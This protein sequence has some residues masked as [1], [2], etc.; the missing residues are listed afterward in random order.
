MYNF[1][2]TAKKVYNRIIKMEIPLTEKFQGFRFAEHECGRYNALDRLSVCKIMYLF[3][4]DNTGLSDMVV[5]INTHLLFC[6]VCCL[7]FL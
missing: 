2:L 5:E 1:N 7:L 6:E 4:K 3:H